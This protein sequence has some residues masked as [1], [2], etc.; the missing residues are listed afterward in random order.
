MGLHNQQGQLGEALAID[1]LRKQG[2]EILETNWKLQHLEADIIARKEGFVV[3]VAVKTR[4]SEH[5]GNPE[6]FIDR[7]KMQACVTLLNAYIRLHGLTEE[8]RID[9]IA[10]VHNSTGYNLQHYPNAF[11]AHSIRR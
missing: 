6:A 3:I 8:G 2:Y 11:S 4:K 1:Y 9:V 10:I 7:K 5:F